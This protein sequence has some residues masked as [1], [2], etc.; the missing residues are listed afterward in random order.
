MK[1]FL[2]NYLKNSVPLAA[3]AFLASACAV[4]NPSLTGVAKPVVQPS[5]IVST[6]VSKSVFFPL[7][8]SEFTDVQADAF[9][10]ETTILVQVEKKG[11]NVKNLVKNDFIVTENGREVKDFNFS[12]EDTKAEQVV[13]IAFVV[14]VTGSMTPFI[15]AAKVRLAEFVKA[16]RKKGYHT[17]MCLSTFGDYTVQKCEKFY[18]N[19]PKDTTQAQT[20]ELIS[21]LSK[22]RAL[23]GDLDPGGKDIPENSMRALMDAGSAPWRSDA[24]KFVILVT[25]AD[26]LYSPDKLGDIEATKGVLPPTMAEIHASLEA[27]Q[28][29]VMAVTPRVAGYTSTFQNLS[30]IVEKSNGEHF[31]FSSVIKRPAILDDILNRIISRVEGTYKVTYNAEKFDENNSTLPIAERKI[32]V[33]LRND[34]DGTVKDQK[35]TAQYPDGRPQYKT[36]W[37]LADKDV[38]ASDAEVTVNGKVANKTD[39]TITGNSITFNKAPAAKA[40]LKV[41][42]YYVDMYA[43]LR[44]EPVSLSEKVDANKL[45]ITLNGIEVRKQDVQIASDMSKNVSITLLPSVAADNHYKITEFQGLALKVE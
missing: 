40:K 29:T 45:K 5:P 10:N 32:E 43:N 39:Y 9:T 36:T 16:T 20:N 23:K 15:E 19:D 18:D 11:T 24:Q 42:Y 44:L 27:S 12:I 31:L 35:A 38:D 21:E 22:L 14:D 7:V 25:D 30:S 17:R 4:E 33:K 28:V 1:L 41:S 37:K 2:K 26:F 3:M 6:T 13:D 34:K 8:P